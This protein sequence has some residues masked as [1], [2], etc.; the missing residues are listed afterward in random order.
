M[1]M[2]KILAVLALSLVVQSSAFADPCAENLGVNFTP[3]QRQKLCKN[4]TALTATDNLET[5]AGAGTNQATGALLSGTK[6][7]HRI[8]GANGIVGWNLPDATAFT[9]GRVHFLLNTTAGAANVYPAIGGNDTINGAAVD[10]VFAALTG[11]K[12][13]MCAQ[14]TAS[15][16]VCS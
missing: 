10:A 2:K 4:L 13:I 9:V 14:F 16:W 12:P 7:I 3:N 1:R 11:I 5:V 6:S 8:T 15:G